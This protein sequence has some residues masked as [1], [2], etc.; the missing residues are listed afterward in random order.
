M[1]LIILWNIYFS[2]IGNLSTDKKKWIF[3]IHNCIILNIVNTFSKIFQT[4]DINLSFAAKLK[5][6]VQATKLRK[7]ATIFMSIK[8][9][10]IFVMLGILN[11]NLQTKETGKQKNI[12]IKYQ[13]ISDFKTP[14][15]VIR[16]PS[17]NTS[18]HYKSTIE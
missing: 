5:K 7:C 13:K 8:K 14:N 4:P 10:K 6:N 9:Q 12:L 16:L 15:I 11:L 17:G 2:W 3:D 1:H 18:R